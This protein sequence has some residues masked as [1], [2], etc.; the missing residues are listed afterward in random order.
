MID[1]FVT[2]ATVALSVWERALIA[3]VIV[4][5]S[6]ITV[7]GFLKEALF[8]KIKNKNLRKSVLAFTS[9]AM[10]LPVTALYFVFDRI[11]FEYFWAACAMLAPVT[12]LVYW[13]YENTQLRTLIQKIGENTFHKLFVWICDNIVTSDS[14]KKKEKLVAANKDLKSFVATELKAT[15]KDLKNL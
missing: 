12:I 9:L 3:G 13:V 4:V 5:C 1:Y 11:S 15:D 7:V 2:A 10:I 14:K 6:V 8:D